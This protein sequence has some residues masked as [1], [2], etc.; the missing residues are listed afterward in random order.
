MFPHPWVVIAF[1]KGSSENLLGVLFPVI[2]PPRGDMGRR[3]AAR[4]SPWRAM[5]WMP[6]MP[7]FA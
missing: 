4:K 7:A 2:F 6:W 5:P 3:A 1:A